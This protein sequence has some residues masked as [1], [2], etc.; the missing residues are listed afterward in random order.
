MTLN[1]PVTEQLLEENPEALFVDG[2]EDAFIGIC[3]RFGQPSLAMY[4]RERCIAVLMQR[5]GMEYDE[6]D[7]FFEF[8]VIGAYVG[9]HTPVFVTLDEL[10]YTHFRG[11]DRV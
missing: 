4:S 7:E 8:N 2:F 9:E 5:D 10:Q 3:R 6:A 1:T 11:L